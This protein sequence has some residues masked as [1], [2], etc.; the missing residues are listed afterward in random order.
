MCAPAISLLFSWSVTSGQLSLPLCCRLDSD[1][2]IR[3]KSES[4]CRFLLTTRGLGLYILLSGDWEIWYTTMA[5]FKDSIEG[6]IVNKEWRLLSLMTEGA[7]VTG[8]SSTMPWDAV[9]GD[10]VR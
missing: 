8:D 10:L 3:P 9:G 7:H 5:T 4:S 1:H 2:G 6:M